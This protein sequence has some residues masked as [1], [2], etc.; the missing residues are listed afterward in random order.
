[1]FDFVY[2][3]AIALR[4]DRR[5]VT[6]LEYALIASLIGLVLVGALTTLGGK[7][8]GTFGNIGNALH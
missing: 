5:A 6:A 7:L 4:H 3:L 2:R 1:M 8:T